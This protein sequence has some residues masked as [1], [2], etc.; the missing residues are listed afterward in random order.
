LPP[1][2]LNIWLMPSAMAET[3]RSGAVSCGAISCACA[4]LMALGV[5]GVKISDS[6]IWIFMDVTVPDK[7]SISQDLIVEPLNFYHN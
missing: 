6:F 7:L 3:Q 1:V 2:F 4:V 5:F